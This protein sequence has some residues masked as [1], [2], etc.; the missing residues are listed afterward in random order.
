M[1]SVIAGKYKGRKLYDLKDLH[2]RPTQAKIRKSIFQI[3][4]PFDGMEVLDL[5]A[6]VG[7]LG[8]EAMSRGATRVVFVENNRRVFK[9]LKKNIE[10]FEPDQCDLFLTDALQFLTR[11]KNQYFDIIFADPPYTKI[12]FHSIK[13]KVESILNPDGIFCMEMKKESIDEP[14]IRVK[15]YGNTQIV[16]W[17]SAA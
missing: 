17:R 9:V 4:E 6:G 2:V 7:T 10:L 15:H 8:I 12:S 5:Y 16:F 3:L 11:S 14:N 1:I 13:E